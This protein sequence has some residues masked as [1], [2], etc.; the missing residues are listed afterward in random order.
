MSIAGNILDK[1]GLSGLSDSSDPCDPSYPGDPSETSDP[2]EPIDPN[3]L[4]DPGDPSDPEM[5]SL[6]ATQTSVP[7]GICLKN[8]VSGKQAGVCT[9]SDTDLS[10]FI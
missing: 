3:D 2:S 6:P 8:L 7:P 10:N 5:F 9:S 4:S 1:F